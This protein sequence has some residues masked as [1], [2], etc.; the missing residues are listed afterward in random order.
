LKLEEI[1][2]NKFA[3]KNLSNKRGADETFSEYRERL[4]ENCKA[5]SEYLKGKAFW[6]SCVD[7][8]IRHP[9]TGQIESIVRHKVK[10][11]YR[12]GMK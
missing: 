1:K 4:K 10:G 6:T 2:L 5:I 8:I 11:T 3:K 12:R 7:E 9:V